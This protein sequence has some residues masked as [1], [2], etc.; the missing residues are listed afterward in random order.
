MLLLV[1]NG[2]VFTGNIAEFLA[3][4]KIKFQLVPF[5]RLYEDDFAKFNSFILSGRRTNNQQMNAINS[6]L[7][8]HSIYEKKPLLGICYGA[9]ILA[10]TVGG[11]IRKM[12]AV[13][14][15]P[16]TIK[17]IRENPLCS[18]MINVYQSHSYEISQLGKHLVHLGESANCRYELI[19]YKD[20]EIF[21]TQF[22]PEMTDDGLKIIENFASLISFNTK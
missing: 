22:H 17:T 3:L 1:D 19:Q 14:K 11:T 7:I 9:E 20:S 10:L 12:N 15:G 8:N 4:K 2:S 13:Q 6:K 18:G 21:G 5:D 16:G